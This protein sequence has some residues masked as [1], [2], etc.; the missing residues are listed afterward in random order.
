MTRPAFGPIKR[1]NINVD[2]IER[3]D[4]YNKMFITI[5]PPPR[6]GKPSVLYGDDMH[7][8]QWVLRK[9]K[10]YIIYPEFDE[11]R[12]LHYHGMIIMTASER[13]TLYKECIPKLTSLLGYVDTSEPKNFNENLR[14]V[15]YCQKEWNDTKHILDIESPI[16]PKKKT[17]SQAKLSP[18]PSELDEG[19]F[20]YFK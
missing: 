20:Q 12:R 8:I 14:T 7:V 18:L 1:T 6:L 13:C 5:S 3:R 2:I 4:I 19:I 16:F 10:R 17:K 9:I 11:K 15:L